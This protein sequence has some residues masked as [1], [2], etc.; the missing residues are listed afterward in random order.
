MPLPSP[1]ASL[2]RFALILH[3]HRHASPQAIPDAFAGDYY[4]SAL[5]A[6]AAKPVHSA[7]RLLALQV[8]R[9]IRKNGVTIPLPNGKKMTIGKDTGIAM[10]SLLF[11]HGLDGTSPILRALCD[12]CSSVRPPSSTSAQTA[13][14]IP[15]WPRWN[16]NLQVVA[17]EPVP[18]IFERLR[19]NVKL[20]HLETSVR[21][22]NSALSSQ[23]G[24]AILFLPAAEALDPGKR[25]NLSHRELAGQKRRSPARCRNRAIR[26]LRSAS[27]HACRSGEDRR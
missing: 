24:R 16:P 4:L 20:N 19:R 10:S 13:A 12:F 23:T 18:A 11:W 22:E 17:F 14:S 15:S 5:L 3:P 6:S 9:K 8:Q 2:D 25:W 27:P 26:R 1:S 21:C 7:S